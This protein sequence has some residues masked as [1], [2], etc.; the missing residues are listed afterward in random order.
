[1]VTFVHSIDSAARQSIFTELN[2]RFCVGLAV[3]DSRTD[4]NVAHK[5]E[6]RVGAKGR[7]GIAAE[8]NVSMLGR[9]FHDRSE[10]LDARSAP[11]AVFNDVGDEI[12][13]VQCGIAAAAEVKVDKEEPRAADDNLVGVEIAVDVADRRG[14]QRRFNQAVAA[15]RMRSMRPDQRALAR[16]HE[17][18]AVEKDTQ[19]IGD[20]VRPLQRQVGAM[21]LVCSVDDSRGEFA[22]LRPG[23]QVRGGTPDTLRYSV[24]ESG[25][26]AQRLG[27]RDARPKNPA[28][29]RPA[30]AASHGTMA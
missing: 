27:D 7:G 5:G 30:P 10:H 8:F 24:I 3:C 25:D 20:G 19:L 16:F 11:Q 14:A 15:Y 23:K 21:Q 26:H 6:R 28:R 29:S 22:P 4:E 9:H 17:R 1:L 2:K 12:S 13:D 18:Q